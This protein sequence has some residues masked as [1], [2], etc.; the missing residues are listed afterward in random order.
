MAKTLTG[1]PVIHT[2]IQ[3]HR[4][5]E[6]MV[7]MRKYIDSNKRLGK[8]VMRNMLDDIS[9]PLMKALDVA[10]PDTL[11]QATER[12]FGGKANEA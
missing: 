7:K 6:A 3:I 8:T 1:R 11:E 9:S 10:T 4:A 12:V 5:I 2:E